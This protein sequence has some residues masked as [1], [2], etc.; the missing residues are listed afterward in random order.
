MAKRPAEPPVPQDKTETARAA[1]RAELTAAP[2]SARE[3]GARGGLREKEVLA[4][5]EQV[6]LGARA[7]GERLQIEPPVCEKCQFIFEDRARLGRP[8]RCPKCKGERIHAPLFSLV[9]LR[10]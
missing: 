7:R 1:I 8:S 5:L 10:S 6:A 9:S 3:L 2:I 4:H